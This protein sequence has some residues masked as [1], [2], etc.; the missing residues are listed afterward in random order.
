M[1]RASLSVA[2]QAW[3]HVIR[4]AGL[5]EAY[6]RSLGVRRSQACHLAAGRTVPSVLVLA[7]LPESTV[8]MYIRTTRRALRKG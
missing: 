3:A 8:L 5:T 7:R 1:T 4:R 2:R 6:L